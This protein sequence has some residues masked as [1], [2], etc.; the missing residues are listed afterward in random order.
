MIT[1]KKIL[2]V[3]SSKAQSSNNQ[4]ILEK[5]GYIVEAVVNGINAIGYL[6]TETDLPDAIITDIFMP[7]IDGFELCVEVKK[8]FPEIPVIILTIHNDDKNLQKAFESGASDYLAKP[9]TKT[10]LILRLTNV[11]LMS[12]S[13]KMLTSML[14]ELRSN[15]KELEDQNKAFCD[16]QLE[17]ARVQ[18]AFNNVFNN[19]DDAMLIISGNN[20][21]DCNEAT[22]KLLNA[23]SK[24][25]VCSTHPSK[26]SPPVQPDGRNSF[27]KANEMIDI[28]FNKGV[29]RFEWMHKKLTGEVFPV[30]VTLI[31]IEYQNELVLHTLWKDLT[32]H[33]NIQK[34][35]L[36]SKERF[37]DISLSTNGLLWEVDSDFH[38]TYCSENVTDILGY[39]QNEL[40]GKTPFVLTS[41]KETVKFD[42]IVKEYFIQ[43]KPLEDMESWHIAKGGK[44]ICFLINGFPVFDENGSFLGYRGVSK[45]ITKRK[46]I[47]KALAKKE[48]QL[49]KPIKN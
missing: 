41:Q 26:L 29:H 25:D 27:E 2:L 31:P 39:S 36:Q 3:D 24:N 13:E 22:V 35:L 32:E 18:S 47:E 8:T 17:S 10:E 1:R 30:E 9:Y 45:D 20:F 48:E 5:E 14:N 42:K 21:I 15:Q 43:R 44:N 46:R 28:A 37:R 6:K 33:K 7:D 4:S 38:F 12:D 16:V 19:S 23:K 40:M 34:N 49:K 11:L